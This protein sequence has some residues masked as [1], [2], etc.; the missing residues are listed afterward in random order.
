MEIRPIATSGNAGSS[1]V[2]DVDKI[3]NGDAFSQLFAMLFGHMIIP[4]SNQN[5]LT[6]DSI[7]SVNSTES[8]ESTENDLLS[9][10]GTLRISS[11]QSWNSDKIES[12]FSASRTSALYSL[13][14]SNPDLQKLFSETGDLSGEMQDF[15]NNINSLNLSGSNNIPDNLNNKIVDISENLDKS[16]AASEIKTIMDALSLQTEENQPAEEPKKISDLFNK[17]SAPAEISNAYS[18]IENSDIETSSVEF[19]KRT[20]NSSDIASLTVN[21][22]VKAKIINSEKKTIASSESTNTLELAGLSNIK[23]DVIND[24]NQQ[25]KTSETALV[26]KPQDIVDIT[27]ERFKTLKLPGSTEVTVK[28][29]P[30]ELGEVSLKLILEKGQINGSI[31]AER[32]EVA[33]MLQNN[34]DQLKTDLKNNNVN[35]NNI[36]VN[37]Q[38]GDNYDSSSRRGFNGKHNKNSHKSVEAFE[39]EIKPYE[40]IE[41]LNIIA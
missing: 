15:I 39:E 41:G 26:E 12:F 11:G 31:S 19:L 17:Q 6:I 33:A 2:Q 7:M 32:K 29:R 16:F 20:T 18:G 1:L 5:N 23:N 9:T 14:S 22:E 27:V 8:T 36:T 25:L 40:L 4:S 38:T 13:L 28:L 30:E 3:Q 24:V 10:F 34:L 35:L 21:N 37:I